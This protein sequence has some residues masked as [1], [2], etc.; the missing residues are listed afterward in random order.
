MT[1]SAFSLA[2][3]V[4]T[5]NRRTQIEQTVARLLAESMTHLVVVDNGSSD[6]SREWL[7]TI[8][9]PR[10]TLLTPEQ[11]LGG[12]GGF[13]L[14]LTHV[15]N[16]IDPDWVVVMDD[17]ARPYPGAFDAF[18]Q[19]DL[20]GW[21]GIAAAVYFPDGTICGM[22]RPILNPFARFSVFIETVRRGGNRAAFHLANPAYDDTET[23]AVDGASFVGLFLSRAG[24]K[25]AGVP[26]GRLFIYAEDGLY[27]LGLTQ[28]GGRLGFMPQIHFEHDCS[29]FTPSGQFSPLWKVYYYHRNLM[30][31]YRRAAGIWFW[32][33]LLAVI[34]KWLLKARHYQGQARRLFL[35]LIR[36][37]IIDGLRRRLD[38]HV[39]RLEGSD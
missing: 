29:T 31:L 22:N 2:V 4:V 39:H 14:G 19:A 21:D 16:V 25:L 5:Y 34:P 10:F 9:D 26:D 20:T 7:A 24:L 36:M 32:L 8:E 12:A 6:G 23:V 28:A 1:Q 33:V 27:T 18:R 35:R 37:A 13:E 15:A 11:N 17:D 30:L 3:V 38:R